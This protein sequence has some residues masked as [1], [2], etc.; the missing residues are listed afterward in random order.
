MHSLE[1]VLLMLGTA[2]LGV[3]LF[4]SFKLPSIL[5]YLAVG[6]LIG[7][8]STGI[9]SDAAPL[10]S[11]A[12]FGVVFMMFT[13]GLGFSLRQLVAMRNIVFG[14][15]LA[16]VTASIFGAIII[17]AIVAFFFPALG[18]SWQAAMTLGAGWA[19]SSTAIVTK[20]LA[21]RM[22][23]ETEYGKRVMGILLFQDL[24]VVILLILVPSLASGEGNL[25][26][27]LGLIVVKAAVMFAVLFFV[28]KQIMNRWLALVARSGSQELFMLNMLLMTLAA[29]WT[30]EKLGL[31]MELGAFSIGML[32]AE[33]RYKTEVESDIRSFRDILLGLYFITIG[34][35]LNIGF[36]EDYWWVVIAIVIGSFLFQ[37]I[38]TTVTARC[39]G[40]SRAVSFKVSLILA[41][42]SEFS[43]V[44]VNQIAGYHMMQEWFLHATLAAMVIS[45][46][47][48]P[49]I[50]IN[51]D[52][53]IS[54]ITKDG[55]LGKEENKPK[56]H[57]KAIDVQRHVILCG[58]GITGQSVAR[59]LYE[60]KVP[61]HALDLDIER[62][63]RAEKAGEPVSYADAVRRENLVAAGID[64]AS[65]VIVTL[66]DVNA[67]LKIIHYAK[68]LNPEAL[69]IVRCNN[70][71]DYER[72][73]NA[74][75][76]EVVSEIMEG[77]LVL[78]SNAM[79]N[80]GV[81]MKNILR[82]VRAARMSRYDS[83]REYFHG[84]TD[85][86]S[87]TD[88]SRHLH[89]LRLPPQSQVI[90]ISMEQLDLPEPKAGIVSVVRDGERIEITPDLVFQE[91]DVLVIRGSLDSIIA[92]EEYLFKAAKK[93]QTETVETL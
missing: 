70:E 18:M 19:L 26:L 80:F 50:I 61:Y 11:L 83:L 20:M 47:I 44:L 7:P 85:P 60:H 89:S 48:A 53:I 39:F 57:V 37:F 72:L 92:G 25:A 36:L 93:C 73:K 3:L 40:V 63:R 32:I 8:Y 10:S 76:D 87:M 52:K 24:A 79:L 30:T 88:T 51:A 15:G 90:G 46:L 71:A 49:F 6:V 14:L 28:G 81:S 43:F 91:E 1:F 42:A 56:K 33:T 74:G 65:S 67:C 23:L 55:W 21:E 34:M 78:A 77:S 68:L 35:M 17:S 75:A 82:S 27:A 31:S 59:M 16:Q 38:V 64:T 13:V 22:E 9:V 12:E 41:Q 45:M 5:G 2:V 4:R 54:R 62:I 29:A 84:E 86:V 69:V 66:K 58:F